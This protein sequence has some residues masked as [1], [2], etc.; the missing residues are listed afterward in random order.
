MDMFVAMIDVTLKQGQEDEIARYIKETNAILSK[1]DG[2]IS[3]RLLRSH[4]GSYRILVEHE[5]QETFQAMHKNPEHD[6]V[7]AKLFE[8]IDPEIKKSLYTV[9]SE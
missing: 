2:F 9:V 5:S 7:R 3:R 4:D 6:K 8:F 1:I